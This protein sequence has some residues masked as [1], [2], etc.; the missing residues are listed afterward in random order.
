M[1]LH[2][3]KDVNN[4]DDPLKN[5]LC[6]F[7][8]AVPPQSPFDSKF[9]EQLELRA[10]SFSFPEIKGDTTEVTWSGHK[11]T[12]AGKQTRDGEWKVKFTEVWSGDVIDGFKKWVNQYH[13]FKNGTISLF[14][15]YATTIDVALLNPSLY[16]PKPEGAVAKNVRLYRAYPTSVSAGEI[17]PSDSAPVEIDVTI[18]YDYFLVGDEID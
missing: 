17:K 6:T 10:Q 5:F 16:K 1:S 11:R 8:I 9:A 7:T 14:K 18:H 3:L 15:E 2:A 13:D 4:L 12:Y